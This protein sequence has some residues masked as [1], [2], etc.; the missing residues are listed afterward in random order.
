MRERGLF[1]FLDQ[2]KGVSR[3]HFLSSSVQFSLAA[4]AL[5]LIHI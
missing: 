2:D 5:S 1:E 3:R 4:S